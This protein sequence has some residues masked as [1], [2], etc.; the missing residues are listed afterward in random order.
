MQ[1][2]L[3]LMNC[4][5]LAGTHRHKYMSVH[6]YISVQVCVW[7]K[8][9]RGQHFG[10]NNINFGNVPGLHSSEAGEGELLFGR[11]DFVAW[12]HVHVSTWVCFN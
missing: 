3:G 8:G 11:S 10:A 12:L 4:I 5:C 6:L 7:G 2:C 1:M 9:L